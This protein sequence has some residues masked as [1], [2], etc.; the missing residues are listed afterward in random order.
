ME[1]PWKIRNLLTILTIVWL[2]ATAG[3]LLIE[4]APSLLGVETN[5]AFNNPTPMPAVG[6]S[7]LRHAAS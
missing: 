1:G 5:P 4:Q 3:I 6:I 2:L 7:L